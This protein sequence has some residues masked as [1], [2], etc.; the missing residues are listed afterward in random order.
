M[1]FVAVVIGGIGSIRGA[2]L[3]GLLLGL[4]EGI[5]LWKIDTAWQSSIAFVV[6]FLVILLRPQGLFGKAIR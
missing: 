6:L 2:V 5:G 1:G 3:G 4:V